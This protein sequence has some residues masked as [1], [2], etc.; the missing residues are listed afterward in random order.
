[1]MLEHLDDDW[2]VAEGLRRAQ[3]DDRDIVV[4]GAVIDEIEKQ[5]LKALGILDVIIQIDDV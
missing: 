2:G 3:N 5:I 4:A 1:M